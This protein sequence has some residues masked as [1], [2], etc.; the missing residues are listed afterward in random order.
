MSQ[1]GPRKKTG[2]FLL[3]EWIASAF[4]GERPA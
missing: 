4:V 2:L 1:P 3:M